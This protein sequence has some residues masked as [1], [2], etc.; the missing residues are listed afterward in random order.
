MIIF[1]GQ[2][3]TMLGCGISSTMTGYRFD[4]AANV[5]RA[6]SDAPLSSSFAGPAAIWSGNRMITWF[7][8]AG[9]RYDPATDFW[10]GVSTDG[11]PEARRSHTLVWT[12]TRMILWGG[13]FAGPVGTGAIYNPQIDP[14]P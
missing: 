12:G 11:A 5:W 10:Q 14:T 2:T 8:N 7:D 1:G 9:G 4:V 6:M 13:E 3:N